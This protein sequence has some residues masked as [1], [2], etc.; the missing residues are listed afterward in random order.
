MPDQAMTINPV[1]QEDLEGNVSYVGSE[2]ETMEDRLQ[3]AE[4]N[5]YFRDD[6]KDPWDEDEGVYAED[7]VDDY[8]EL[9]GDTATL[10]R[11]AQDNYGLEQIEHLNNLLDGADTELEN[12]VLESI[13]QDMLDAGAFEGLDD[14][15]EEEGDDD[16]F[17]PLTEDEGEVY[18]QIVTEL[19]GVEPLGEE[20]A[21]YLLQ[22]AAENQDNP[23]MRDMLLASA[24][25]HVGEADVDQIAQV[26]I[27]EYG[28]SSVYETYQELV[29][30]FAQ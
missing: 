27:Q 2:V 17:S 10:L 11:W 18:E 13:F 4:D 12:A 8:E 3:S 25:Y 16:D 6:L 28:K 9:D 14:D 15:Y 1:Y 5:A 20:Q 26:L 19:V 23:L 24:Q 30:A 29:E 22:A 7:G 21:D